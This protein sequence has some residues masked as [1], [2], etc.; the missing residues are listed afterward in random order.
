MRGFDASHILHF[1]CL[2]EWLQESELC[3][4]CQ[5][6]ITEDAVS[7]VGADMLVDTTD[8]NLMMV[9]ELLT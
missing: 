5:K 3:P 8:L 9:K 4:A 6:A 7:P 2:N 1:D